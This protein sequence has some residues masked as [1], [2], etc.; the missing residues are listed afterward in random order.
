MTRSFFC[1]CVV[2][3]VTVKRVFAGGD[4]VLGR[5]RD[6]AFLLVLGAGGAGHYGITP[7]HT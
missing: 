6:A 7:R 3:G 1:A 2:L 5:R 4:Q